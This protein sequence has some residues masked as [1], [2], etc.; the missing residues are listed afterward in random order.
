[1]TPRFAALCADALPGCALARG[2]GTVYIFSQACP[3]AAHWQGAAALSLAAGG[4]ADGGASG[5]VQGA[6]PRARRAEPPAS[7][8][9]VGGE[10]A[11]AC[12]T[13]L[14]R[15]PRRLTSE[16]AARRSARV[17]LLAAN[18]NGGGAQRGER[19]LPRGTY[20]ARRRWHLRVGSCRLA[21]R[22]CSVD[23]K[24]H[25]AHEGDGDAW[26]SRTGSSVQHAR[27]CPSPALR[28]PCSGPVAPLPFPAMRPP[29]TF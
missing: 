9:R 13:S 4:A 22:I 5:W 16:P 19:Q 21:K 17:H 23:C 25:A 20:P 11:P 2:R 24:I 26:A 10:C 27:Y 15:G 8:P 14:P 28:V 1:M 12:I 18:A 7:G 29:G 3:R 6:P